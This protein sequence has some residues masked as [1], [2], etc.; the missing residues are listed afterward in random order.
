MESLKIATSKQLI[1]NFLNK[2]YG[3]NKSKNTTASYKVD[4][5]LFVKYLESKNS[6][7]T[8]AT[9]DTL[10]GYKAYLRDVTYTKKD[11]KG[12]LIIMHYS[13]NTRARRISSLKSF[14]EFL[15]KRKIIKENVSDDLTIP[16]KESG[17]KPVYMSLKQ[18]QKLIK[19]T[20][21]ELHS[22]RDKIIL[23]MFL[24]T[25][26]RLSEL[27]N[28]DTTD[29]TDGI[30]TI[31]NGKGNKTREVNI[32]Q[33]LANSIKEYLTTRKFTDGKAMFTSQKGNRMSVSAV[34]W[35][36]DKYIDKAGLD[37]TIYS[38]HKLRHTAATLMLQNNDDIT[39][40]REN[41]GHSSLKTTQIYAHVLDKSKQESAN[42]MGELFK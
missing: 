12:N 25:G 24:T 41:L 31:R 34:Q 5:E 18:S 3:D 33:N 6:T 4:L 38:T 35:L 28:L 1:E 40:I 20:E 15:Y 27:I 36:V 14:Y 2:L 39:T 8:E 7:I 22:F 13:E 17:S 29:I 26:M 16:K 37:T 9:I 30:I 19:G 32:N 10:E 42:K 11:K 23:T 21:G